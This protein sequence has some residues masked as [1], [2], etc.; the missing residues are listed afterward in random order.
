MWCDDS[1][2]NEYVNMSAEELEAWLGGEESAGAGWAK[3]DGSGE[4]IGHE[5]FDIP[6]SPF[7][8]SFLW[9]CL[10]FRLRF[11][12]RFHLL[13]SAYHSTHYCPLTLQ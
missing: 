9:F 13:R 11:R 12:F 10:H 7:F 5:R 3:D 2:F 8:P 4:T 1:E 6:P